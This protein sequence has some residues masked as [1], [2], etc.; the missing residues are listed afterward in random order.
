MYYLHVAAGSPR[1]CYALVVRDGD[2]L[3]ALA[4]GRE[5][6]LDGQDAVFAEGRLDGLGIRALRQQELTVVLPV[7]GLCVGLLLVLGVD[8]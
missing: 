4:E 7:D 2:E 5:G 1:R 6:R 8:L 3:L